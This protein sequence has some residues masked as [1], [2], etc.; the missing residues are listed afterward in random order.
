V[1]LKPQA[2]SQATVIGAMTPMLDQLLTFLERW[3]G[4]PALVGVALVVLN[5]VAGFLP[6]LPWLSWHAWLLHL[7]VV[8]GLLGL[9]LTESL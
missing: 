4:L 9:L 1:G 8:V 3:R 2:A 6:G 7:G 5:F